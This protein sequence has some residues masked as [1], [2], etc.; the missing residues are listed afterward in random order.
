MRL[1]RLH[2]RRR[3]LRWSMAASLAL[4][5]A[6]LTLVHIDETNAASSDSDRL[7]D[8]FSESAITSITRKFMLFAL[9]IRLVCGLGPS[10]EGQNAVFLTWILIVLRIMIFVCAVLAVQTMRKGALVVSQVYSSGISGSG[11]SASSTSSSGKPSSTLN[12]AQSR[13]L[14]LGSA[15]GVIRDAFKARKEQ[16]WEHHNSNSSEAKD[17]DPALDNETTSSN[18][19]IN[20]S[21]IS[22]SYMNHDEAPMTPEV[23]RRVSY[24]S[25]GS[26]ASYG[27]RRR[28]ATQFRP[29]PSLQSPGYMNRPASSGAS[30]YL[31]SL[32]STPGKGLNSPMGTPN[33]MSTPSSTTCPN[34]AS[35]VVMQFSPF[36]STSSISDMDEAAY[37][38]LQ[39]LPVDWDHSVVSSSSGRGNQNVANVID[40][41]T[42]NLIRALSK[43][44]R[45]NIIE[46]LESNT[47][48]LIELNNQVFSRSVLDQSLEAPILPFGTSG[49]Q[50]TALGA[51]G[52]NGMGQLDLPL[53]QHQQQLMMVQ[54]QQ[55]PLEL[56]RQRSIQYYSNLV[57]QQPNNQQVLYQAQ[58]DMNSI[59]RLLDER[60]RLEKSLTVVANPLLLAGQG[61]YNKATVLA[62]L[63]SLFGSP[64]RLSK[65]QWDAVAPP[66]DA[67]I[68]IHIACDWLKRSMHLGDNRPMFFANP[69][70]D[71]PVPEPGFFAAQKW[72]GLERT[73][74]PAPDGHSVPHFQ[75]YFH[76]CLW[77]VRSGRQN[78]LQA[79]ALLIYGMKVRRSPDIEK[80]EWVIGGQSFSAI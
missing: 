18:G 25:P 68:L 44:A 11:S 33:G 49:Q 64:D 75:L 37:L 70:R 5:A 35:P 74:V 42:D 69:Q 59:N 60:L 17:V 22:G 24:S 15:A 78:A 23:R 36:K 8:E 47:R 14:G 76:G 34:C 52:M 9:T 73:T 40:D 41:W 43:Y 1:H 26:A 21:K 51:G 32:R 63:K 57:Q 30:L 72:W 61:A 48:S 58:Q 50:P 45:D 65:Y 79:I 10:Y 62:H 56:A 67:D 55:Q 13:L 12:A 7:D 39:S 80:V 4:M 28:H 6:A 20:K 77:Q 53:Q 16:A 38:L 2:E 54:Q 31:A 19:Y 66:C 71:M 3:S 29:S 46:P 27:V